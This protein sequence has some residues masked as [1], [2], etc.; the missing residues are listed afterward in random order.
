VFRVFEDGTWQLVGSDGYVL[1]W[2]REPYD[3]VAVDT[4]RYD[5]VL[6]FGVVPRC[7]HGHILL[8]CGVDTCPEQNAYLAA[9]EAALAVY[10]EQMRANA[11]AE[12]GLPRAAG[13]VR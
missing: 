5:E 7:R 1:D 10:E 4:G 3:E 12:I 6:T 8:A 11:R 2:C 13:G 9:Q